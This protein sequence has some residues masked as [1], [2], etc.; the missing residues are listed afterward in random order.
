MTRQN[1]H[2]ISVL[3]VAWGSIFA[4]VHAYWALGGDAA[5]NETADSVA[6]SLYIGFVALLGVAGAAVARGLD[7][8][9]GE[10]FGIARLRLTARTGGA[11]L[12]TGV[13]IGTVRWI[14]DGSLG[15][16][17]A[18]GIAITSYF[19]LGAILF[20]ALGF[21]RASHATP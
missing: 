13:V 19:L 4:A 1:L 14:V 8:P 15:D 17:A 10:R 7:R 6:A 16:H 20:L 12:A 18:A 21:G 9:W 11:M 5:L 2:R 3:T